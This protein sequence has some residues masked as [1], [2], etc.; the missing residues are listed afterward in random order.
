MDVLDIINR[1]YKENGQLRSIL[2]NHS[3]RVAEKALS[4]L[5]NHPSIA[6]DRDFVYT[7][8]MLHDIGIVRC[9]APG[10][11]C[12]GAEPYIRHG[13]CGAKMLLEDGWDKLFP[14]GLLVKWARVCERHTGAGL[15]AEEIRAQ[16]MPLPERDFLPETIEE[17]LICYADKF[18]SKSHIDEEK[19]IE[20][21]FQ[22]MR[23]YS[24][25]S[26]HRFTAL[27]ELFK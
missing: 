26:L 21:V 20:R 17:K 7:A 1:Y 22:T 16:K 15:T 23:K 6:A 2:L 14:S 8:A 12:Y 5:D 11:C 10:I 4:V 27:H 24:E 3:K 18:Y 9:N 25:G 19:P 13:I